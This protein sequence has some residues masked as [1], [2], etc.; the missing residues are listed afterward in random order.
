MKKMM[1]SVALALIVLTGCTVQVHE[2]DPMTI[3][4]IEFAKQ[5]HAEDAD[6]DLAPER[7]EAADAFFDEWLKYEEAKETAEDGD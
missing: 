2:Q 1:I 5:M 4:N 3:Q 7:Q 6:P